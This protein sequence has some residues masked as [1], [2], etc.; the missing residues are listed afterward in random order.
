MRRNPISVDLNCDVGEG[1][2]N[3]EALFPHLSSCSIACGGHAGDRRTMGEIARLSKA[4]GIRAGAHPSYPDRE[5]FGRRSLS[6][7]PAE[8]RESLSGQIRLLEEA[9]AGAGIRLR[10]IKA[11]G[12]LYNDLAADPGLGE[13]YLNI[14][15]PFKS[16]YILYVPFGSRFAKTAELSGFRVWQ[17]GFADRAYRDDGSLV[18]R[19]SPG[20][21]LHEPEKVFDQVRQMVREHTVTTSNNRVIPLRPETVCIHGDNA[22]ALR[23]LAYLTLKLPDAG[24]RKST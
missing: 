8:L 14:L 7:T 18:S 17:E 21:V 1:L 11:H 5:H 4:F 15:E 9:A 23:I 19:T 2:G 6:L 10:H 22:E 12:A 24:I 16:S 13:Q 3:E 20:A